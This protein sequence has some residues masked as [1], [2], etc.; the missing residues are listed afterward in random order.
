LAQLETGLTPRRREK[1]DQGKKDELT[2]HFRA[3][4]SVCVAYHVDTDLPVAIKRVGLNKQPPKYL[5]VN[6]ILVMRSSRHP[7]TVNHIESIL[8]NNDLWT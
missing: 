2:P 1:K 7:N 3:S 4:G 8:Y 5:V 6:E